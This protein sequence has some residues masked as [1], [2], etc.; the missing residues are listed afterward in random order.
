MK[1]NWT[2]LKRCCWTSISL[3][4]LLTV[5]YVVV[6]ICS[7]CFEGPVGWVTKRPFSSQNYFQKRPL[8]FKTGF[9][10]WIDERRYLN[11]DLAFYY[12][13][14]SQVFS[15]DEEDIA[16][17]CKIIPILIER[18]EQETLVPREALGLN[19]GFYE[20]RFKDDIRVQMDLNLS[21]FRLSYY[22]VQNDLLQWSLS[23]FYN[24]ASGKHTLETWQ[25]WEKYSQ[26]HA[27]RE[28]CPVEKRWI[29]AQRSHDPELQD[30]EGD[31]FALRSVIGEIPINTGEGWK[32]KMDLK[33]WQNLRKLERGDDQE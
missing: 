20:L 4:G 1:L 17:L 15:L 9:A 27:W 7:C 2:L 13:A 29:L 5:L 31:I 22:S 33:F 14:H 23:P 28:M 3:I 30:V 12:Y 21:G 24:L 32:T 8:K 11:G 19:L 16:L 18:N 25:L 6:M 26:R 10:L